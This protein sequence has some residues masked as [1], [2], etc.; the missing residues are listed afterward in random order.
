MRQIGSLDNERGAQ[1][2]V[3]YLLTQGIE[4]QIDSEGD[5]WVIWVRE[6][7]QL[8][9]SKAILDQYREQPSDPKY[10]A[11]RRS[12]DQLR[13][14]SQRQRAAA[15]RR[16]ISMRQHWN[17]PLARRAPLILALIGL[18]TFVSLATN[19]GRD[20]GSPLLWSLLFGEPAAKFILPDG[21]SIAPEG[22]PPYDPLAAIRRGELWRMVT[23]IFLHGG[24]LHLL[25]NMWWIYVL[26][27]QMESKQGTVRFGGLV[28]LLALTSNWAQFLIEQN[29][30][31]MGMSG[32]VYGLFGYIGIKLRL[33]PRSGYLLGEGTV[34]I[35]LLVLVMGFLRV[36]PDIA[37]WAH[38]G[39]LVTGMV[40]AYAARGRA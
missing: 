23:P 26:G 38:L 5:R 6:E 29:P 8:E 18:S 15:A 24:P 22:V 1:T 33:D 39:G 27:V 14:Q 17:R 40:L 25:F 32:V 37:N 36:I 9:R 16:S 28:L 7:N 10:T 19:W 2:L 3:D 31:F 21:T 13:S 34:F 11:A 12:A 20:S 4:A 30:M 35:M